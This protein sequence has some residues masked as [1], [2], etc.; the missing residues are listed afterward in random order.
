VVA[1]VQKATALASAGSLAWRGI[2][3]VRSFP[4]LVFLFLPVLLAFM[5]VD[6]TLSGEHTQMLSLYRLTFFMAH[7]PVL[8]QNSFTFYFNNLE[9]GM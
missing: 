8:R 7:F 3:A 2:R 6:F 1:S 5:G 9:N 4:G